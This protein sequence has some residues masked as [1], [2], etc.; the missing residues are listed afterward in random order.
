[1]RARA[2]ASYRQPSS[3]QHVASVLWCRPLICPNEHCTY[4]MSISTGNK[5]R[6]QQMLS[7]TGVNPL[8][9]NPELH[10]SH[11][12]APIS[13]TS[14]TRPARFHA[15]A[16]PEQQLAVVKGALESAASRAWEADHFP[17]PFLSSSNKNAY[18]HHIIYNNNNNTT[19]TAA[20]TCHGRQLLYLQLSTLD[21]GSCL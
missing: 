6:C 14:R 5:C 12:F 21:G 1:M 4:K 20:K 8:S 16:A 2:M 7:L 19:T 3:H 13:P 15:P 17:F 11:E 9:A 18:Y 10:S